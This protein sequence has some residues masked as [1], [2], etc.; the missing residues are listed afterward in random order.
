MMK[1]E[2]TAPNDPAALLK[3]MDDASGY[4]LLPESLNKRVER[5]GQEWI[6]DTFGVRDRWKVI[7]RHLGKRDIGA[8]MDLGGHS[9][10]FSLS[11]V[12]SGFATSAR[13]YDL[14]TRA[15]TVGALSARLM[16]IEDRV[17]FIQEPLSIDFVENMPSSDSI[18]CLNLIHHAGSTFDTEAVKSGGW[19]DYAMRWLSALRAK[20]NFAVVGIGYKGRSKPA[21][22]HAPF[23]QRPRIFSELVRNTGW[24][25]EYS[26][27]VAD[28]GT[29]GMR[30][31][32]GLREHV[33]VN[34]MLHKMHKKINGMRRWPRKTASY[35]LYILIRE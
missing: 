18:F 4:C 25:I 2:V 30:F 28:I 15:L 22:W 9:G 21:E 33:L 11:A 1:I 16:S 12:E 3:A 24:T 29:L 32:D 26:G 35:H 23:Y 7:E 6:Q 34:K 31:A 13:V 27:N 14:D 10:Y 8:V 19:H 17:T 5:G 20:A